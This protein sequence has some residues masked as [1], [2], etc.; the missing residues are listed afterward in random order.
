[1]ALPQRPTKVSLNSVRY[2][3]VYVHRVG[4][5]H[6]YHFIG[7]FDANSGMEMIKYEI[8]AWMCV[9]KS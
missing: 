2:S 9:E 1:M 7:D 5:S 4:G 6:M 8:E 3:Y